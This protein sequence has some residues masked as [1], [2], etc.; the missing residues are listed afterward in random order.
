MNIRYLGHSCL[1]ISDGSHTLIIDPFL[2]GNPK[3]QA[4]ADEIRADHILVTHGHN[5]HVG[6][7]AQIAKKTGATVVSTPEV[8]AFM[9]WQDVRA[10]GMNIG[11]TFDLGYAKVKMVQAFHSSGYVLQEERRIVYMGM[12]T[13]LIV[14]WNG[15]SIMHTGDTGLFGDMKLIGERNRIDLAFLPIGGHFTMGPEDALL[16]AE[17]LGASHVVPIHY[18]TFP[19]I[20]Q[21][22]EAFVRALGDKGIRGTAMRPGDTLKL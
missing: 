2:S 19:L 7:T 6:D 11:G 18:D 16:A 12:P 9:G 15:H 20:A 14:E 8:A 4:T 21:D 22:G 13:G 10:V 17:W 3:A 1:E 5:D